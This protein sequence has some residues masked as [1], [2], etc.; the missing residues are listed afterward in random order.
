[1]PDERTLQ[2]Q[3]MWQALSP[4]E[5]KEIT[6]RMGENARNGKS[7]PKKPEKPTTF[8]LIGYVRC[9]LGKSDRE[10]F[11]E[12]QSAKTDA[13]LFD[14]LVKLCDGGYLLKAGSGK[15][16]HQASL[17]DVDSPADCGGYVLSAFASEAR[18]SLALLLYKHHVMMEGDWT[19]Y[20]GGTGKSQLR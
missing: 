1:M 11:R 3:T 7:T 5:Q 17:S 20:L 8:E 15:E 14:M 2:Q 10:P 16:G 19:S 12:W 9:E 18:D 4:S 13:E 6:R